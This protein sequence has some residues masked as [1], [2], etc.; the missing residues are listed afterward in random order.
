MKSIFSQMRIDTSSRLF[1]QMQKPTT[2]AEE[3]YHYYIPV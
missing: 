2:E 1:I 3:Y